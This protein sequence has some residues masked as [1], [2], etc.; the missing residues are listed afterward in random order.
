MSTGSPRALVRRPSPRLAD[1]VV[2]HLERSSDV[3]ADLALEQW[4][5]YVDQL[6]SA[7]YAITE[8]AAAPELAD[9]VFIEDTMVVADDL[10]VMCVIGTPSR[11]P[12]IDT[13]RAAA[14]QLGL[15]VV[16][17]ADTP[18]EVD[19]EGPVQLDG[20][21]VLKVGSTVYV[22]VG[23]RTT[24]AGAQA[25]GQHLASVGRTVRPVRISKTLH[26]K[27]QVT[28]LPDGTVVG[29][30]PLVDDPGHWESTEGF[31]AVPEEEGAHVIVIGEQTV[32]MSDAAPRSAALF[33]DRRLTV[34][35]VPTSE[36]AKLEG[37]VTCLSVR[38]HPYD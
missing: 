8:V 37:C 15:R 30:P 1:G 7:G 24:A 17:L 16:E 9:G 3:D 25:L 19:A 22:G 29:Y 18:G 27:S 6:Q 31:L 12:E 36:I 34:V 35:E 23:G 13:A 28:A 38:L 14:Q 20:G 33:R 10:A 4:Q 32:L 11:L 2:T 26:L 21:D 5:E